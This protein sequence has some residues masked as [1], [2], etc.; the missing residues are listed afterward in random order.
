MAIEDGMILAR[1]LEESAS[2]VEALQRYEAA[3]LNRTSRIV[4]SASELMR[5]RDQLADPRLADAF[6]ERLST[7]GN[8]YNWIH[9]YDAVNA[10]L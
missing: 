1:C 9:Q 6:V 7:S 10:P 5:T 2:I 8:D 4:Q 3:R